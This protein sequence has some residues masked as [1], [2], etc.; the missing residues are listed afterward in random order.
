MLPSGNDAAMSLARWGGTLIRGNTTQPKVKS[1]VVRM[2]EEAKRL[3]LKDT[4]YGN[5]HG[6]P[7]KN[8]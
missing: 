8:S 2:N 1:F 7:N 6:L 3:D 4:K 5:P